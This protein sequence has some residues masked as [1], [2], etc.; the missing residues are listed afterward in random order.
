MINLK[1]MNKIYLLLI[2]SLM[3]IIAGCGGGGGGGGGGVSSDGSASIATGAISLSW[4]PPQYNIDGSPITDLG[5][6]KIYYGQ[7]TNN[8]TN[9]IDLGNNAEITISSLTE[10]TWCFTTTAYDVSGN[11][12]DYSNEV[13]TEISVS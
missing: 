3:L 13:C 5:G 11:E 12:S 2:P 6:Y 10:G 9:S 8:Y 7:G 1:K 4:N